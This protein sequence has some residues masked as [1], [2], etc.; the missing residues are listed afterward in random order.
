MNLSPESQGRGVVWSARGIP[1][2]AAKPQSKGAVIALA[3][4]SVFLLLPFAGIVAS[5][6]SN[7]GGM[8]AVVGPLVVGVF[9]L[10]LLLAVAWG[11]LRVFRAGARLVGT[12]LV[13]R[14]AVRTRRVDLATA[15]HVRLTSSGSGWNAGAAIPTLDASMDAYHRSLTVHFPGARRGYL[16]RSEVEALVA[17]IRAGQRT[18]L[19]AQQA[20]NTIGA[21]YLRAS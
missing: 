13:A 8:L 12:E 21:L 10:V 3:V 20:E 14:G 4:V 9:A 7:S 15:R 2:S 16:P 19:E 18:G 17:A 1:L 6:L 11:L 5:A